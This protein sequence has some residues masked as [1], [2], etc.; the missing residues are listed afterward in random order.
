LFSSVSLRCLSY[1]SISSV[2]IL[3]FSSLSGTLTL[4]YLS[5]SGWPF[6]SW[7]VG[8]RVWKLI[9]AGGGVGLG[10]EI[11][12]STAPAKGNATTPVAVAPPSP[13]VDSILLLSSSSGFL[14]FHSPSHFSSLHL[15][16]ILPTLPVG[17]SLD[18]DYEK[19]KLA[20]NGTALEATSQEPSVQIE[21]QLWLKAYPPDWHFN[22][23]A[24]N[25]NETSNDAQRRPPAARLEIVLAFCACGVAAVWLLAKA[26]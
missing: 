14:P 16:A 22:N 11:G 15:S 9:S 7:I 13:T 2:R 10:E 19:T 1:H 8:I 18:V 5:S 23:S 24:S 25:N 17:W 21:T 6:D 26:S 4:S 20:P 12:T 3:G